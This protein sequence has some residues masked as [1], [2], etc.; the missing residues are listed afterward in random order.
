MEFS[1]SLGIGTSLVRF[2]LT[3]NTVVAFWTADREALVVIFSDPG[4]FYVADL[5][6]FIFASLLVLTFGAGL[7]SLDTIIVKR[8]KEQV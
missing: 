2:L 1:S 8:L 5:Y 7:L 4:K 3:S 6:T